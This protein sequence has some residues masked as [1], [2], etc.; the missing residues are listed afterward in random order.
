MKSKD[1]LEL[2][3]AIATLVRNREARISDQTHG[4]LQKNWDEWLSE[5]VQ[6]GCI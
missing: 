5:V 3:N 4:G 2:E 1:L 6:R